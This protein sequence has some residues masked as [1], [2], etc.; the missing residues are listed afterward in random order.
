M[1]EGGTVNGGKEGGSSREKESREKGGRAVVRS[2]G[3]EGG[4]YK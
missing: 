4:G 1:K 2:E 3:R